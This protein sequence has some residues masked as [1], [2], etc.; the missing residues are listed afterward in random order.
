MHTNDT[1]VQS[2][3][4][5]AFPGLNDVHQASVARVKVQFNDFHF[6]CRVHHLQEKE[7]KDAIKQIMLNDWSHMQYSGN[8]AYKYF[9]RLSQ[10]E[11]DEFERNATQVASRDSIII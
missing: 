3:T 4:G 6:Q 8:D 9:V 5:F 1:S 7:V 11:L 10:Q 2:C